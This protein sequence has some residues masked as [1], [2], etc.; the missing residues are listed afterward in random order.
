MAAG[1]RS[2][3]ILRR[4]INEALPYQSL[5]RDI[6][7]L[8]AVFLHA[9]A[10]LEHRPFGH[11]Q[12]HRIDVALYFPLRLNFHRLGPPAVYG[13]FPPDDNLL[14]GERGQRVTSEFLT[15]ER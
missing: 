13:D 2:Y 3:R 12:A 5:H 15:K 7:Q 14:A 10:P 9:G 4:P 6:F 11:C 8:A 1:F